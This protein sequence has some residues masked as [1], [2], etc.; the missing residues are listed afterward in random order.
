MPMIDIYAAADI[1]PEAT[2]R[3]L[4]EAVTLAILRAEGV[5]APG[6]FHLDNTAVYLHRMPASAVQTASTAQARTVRVQV[7]TPPGS[8]NREGQKQAT[9]EITEIVARISGDAT[10]AARTW[11]VLTEAAEGGWGMFGT[12][13]GKQEFAALAARAKAAAAG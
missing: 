1:F 12:A 9:K 4:G 13:F 8:L 5:A 2:D 11:V 7:I 10:I 6:P 3:E